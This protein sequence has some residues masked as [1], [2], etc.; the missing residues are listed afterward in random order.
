MKKLIE[1][2]NFLI[3]TGFGFFLCK[4]DFF[5][6]VKSASVTKCIFLENVSNVESVITPS[7]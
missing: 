6:N 7:K 5:I 3:K 4:F 1:T 2:T